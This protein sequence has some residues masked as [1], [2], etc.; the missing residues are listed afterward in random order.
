LGLFLL[1]QQA[2]KAA[3]ADTSKPATSTSNTSTVVASTSSGATAF[4]AYNQ[5][6]I[7]TNR[8]AAAFT[9][10]SAAVSTKSENAKWDE[11]YLMYEEV[12]DRAEKGYAR[13]V[14]NYGALN[15]EVGGCPRVPCAFPRAH[16]RKADH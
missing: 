1:S 13:M 5:A 7:S 6:P 2:A 4:P 10:T 12:K 3:A 9:S 14:T 11:E 15:F 8:T 16:F